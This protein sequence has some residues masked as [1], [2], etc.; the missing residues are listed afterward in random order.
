MRLSVG[1]EGWLDA[2]RPEGAGAPSADGPVQVGRAGVWRLSVPMRIAAAPRELA[3]SLWLVRAGRAFEEDEIALMTE[4]VGKAKLAAAEIIAHHAIREEAMTDPLTGLGNRRRL[5]SDLRAAF[6][7]DAET[8]A[9]S[10]L[11]LFD[12]DGFKAYNDTFGHLAGDELLARLGQRLSRA[13]EGCGHAYRLGGDE[14]C[15]HL[16]LDRRRSGST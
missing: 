12:L 5:T 6:E 3:G 4:L 9:P 8:A 14:F 7:E 16:D 1:V 13:V 10:L 15:A 11:L 2:M